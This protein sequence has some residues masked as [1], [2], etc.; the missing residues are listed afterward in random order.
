M[1]SRAALRRSCAFAELRCVLRPGGELRWYEHVLS[2]KPAPRL[3]QRAVGRAF[4]PRAFGGCRTARGTLATIETAGFGIDDQH[5]IRGN[6]VPVAFGVGRHA[7]GRACRSGSSPPAGS[8]A[9]AGS[10]AVEP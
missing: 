3:S 9:S 1:D 10:G 7:I 6:L 4:S 5:R 2:V 8:G